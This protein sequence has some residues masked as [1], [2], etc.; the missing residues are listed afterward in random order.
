M[1]RWR[2]RSRAGGG[3][4]CNARGAPAA[5]A[6]SAA[7]PAAHPPLRRPRPPLLSPPP[8]PRGTASP[9]PR[10]VVTC[11]ARASGAR[12]RARRGPARLRPWTAGA[13]HGNWRAG[14]P[15]EPSRKEA[16][17][18]LPSPGSGGAQKSELITGKGV[19]LV[20]VLSTTVG[21]GPADLWGLRLLWWAHR[22]TYVG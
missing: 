10:G 4:Q 16:A 15:F 18:R 14:F 12:T 22:E 6:A 13:C 3:R 8:P 17:G 7:A 21:D 2:W 11:S 5:P 1:A 9:A 20:S 19:G